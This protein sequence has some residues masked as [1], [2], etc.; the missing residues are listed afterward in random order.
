MTRTM[1]GGPAVAA[2]RSNSISGCRMLVDGRVRNAV[3]IV[4]TAATLL[5]EDASD[6]SAA[7]GCA[8]KLLSYRWARNLRNHD[9]TPACRPVVWP[10]PKSH[11]AIWAEATCVAPAGPGMAES[12]AGR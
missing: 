3:V 8:P 2:D 6:V 12:S 9:T 7:L 5:G 10:S 11:Q 4:C 1:A